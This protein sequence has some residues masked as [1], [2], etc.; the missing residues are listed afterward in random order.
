MK[1]PW[2]WQVHYWKTRISRP[3]GQWASCCVLSKS[4]SVVCE[5]RYPLDHRNTIISTRWHH[6]ALRSSSSATPR[7]G[8]HTHT[9][10]RSPPAA[11]S[12]CSAAGPLSAQGHAGQCRQSLSK[13]W[14]NT[15]IV[16]PSFSHLTGQDGVPVWLEEG[17]GWWGS[18][19][20]PGT[21]VENVRTA[22]IINLWR[23]CSHWEDMWTGSLHNTRMSPSSW[24]LRWQWVSRGR[25]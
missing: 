1:Y 23:W 15:A 18:S 11:Q 24:P 6:S 17:V 14:S 19:V 9:H 3:P 10:H 5:W 8:P 4:H 13:P 22:Q 16:T 12:L 2:S 7:H 25:S 20:L 21:G